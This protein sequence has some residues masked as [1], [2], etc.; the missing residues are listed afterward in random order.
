MPLG[1]GLGCEPEQLAR[2]EFDRR[3]RQYPFFADHDAVD[4]GF[5]LL[6]TLV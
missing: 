4:G 2:V 5:G 3:S 1:L 6:E